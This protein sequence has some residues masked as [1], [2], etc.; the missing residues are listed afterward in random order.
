MKAVILKHGSSM[1]DCLLLNSSWRLCACTFE[2]VGHTSLSHL[3]LWLHANSL[4][5]GWSFV[6]AGR[7][8]KDPWLQVCADV[9]G[10]V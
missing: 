4:Q 8:I 9:P 3:Q 10:T 2:R 5:R 6:K 1:N 7:H